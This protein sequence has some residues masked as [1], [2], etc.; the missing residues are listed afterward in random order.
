MSSPI[1]TSM[2]DRGPVSSEVKKGNPKKHDQ[3]KIRRSMGIFVNAVK[4]DKVKR[5]VFYDAADRDEN[6]VGK[7]AFEEGMISAV[8]DHLK[9]TVCQKQPAAVA[10]N[11]PA[12][13]SDDEVASE[14]N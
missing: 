1:S 9:D 6:D 5:I 2:V 14:D 7:A 12:F 13:D 8:P 3:E 11:N 10:V 4:W